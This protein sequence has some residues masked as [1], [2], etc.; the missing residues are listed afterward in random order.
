M[1]RLFTVMAAALVVASASAQKQPNNPNYT[2][3]WND[4]IFV[5]VGGGGQVSLKD[6]NYSNGFW[7]AVQPNVYVG[8]GKMINPLWS[9]RIEASGWRAMERTP[10]DNHM[11]K[12]YVGANLDAIFNLTN[13]VLGYNPDKVFEL[14]VFAGPGATFIK[15]KKD[16]I[17]ARPVVSAGLQ[18]KFNFNKF[19]SLDIE[20]RMAGQ[21]D[22]VTQKGHGWYATLTGGLTYTFG[23][24]KF[25]NCNERLEL[26][27]AE[28]KMLNDQVNADKAQISDLENQLAA[29]KRA[30]ANK[31]APVVQTVT[32]DCDP[33]AGPV[34]V[35][36]EIG[37]SNIDARGKA[38][39]QLAAKAVKA[40]P[41]GKYSVTGY[42]D[43]ATGTAKLNQKL[44]EKRAKAV[45][46][47]LIAAGVDKAQLE[48]VGAGA[49]PNMFNSNAL[50]RVVIVKRK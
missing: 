31:P 30:A 10:A 33:T 23:G 11:T 46:D 19:L 20:G 47:A 7:R 2:E 25:A 13:W 50:N 3:K 27:L 34:A 8:L 42:A 40:D 12:N 32:K 26:C 15:N 43:K 36:F 14:S 45:Y 5:S 6:A 41:N 9:G 18:A 38:N 21:E 48:E 4:N 37:K 16:D 17:T 29:A 22:I 28:Q 44:S 35:F 1:K 24:K 49:Q 39:I